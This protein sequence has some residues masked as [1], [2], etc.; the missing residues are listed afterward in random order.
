M[1]SDQMQS[2]KIQVL[3]TEPFTIFSGQLCTL[4]FGMMRRKRKT[5][6]ML[7]KRTISH[8]DMT[9]LKGEVLS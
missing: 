6:S 9:F 7:T 4:I 3:Y 1:Q 8:R 2:D 5:I